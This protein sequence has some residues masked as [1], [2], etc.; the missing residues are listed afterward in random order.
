MKQTRIL[1]DENVQFSN[2]KIAEMKQLA[3]QATEAIAFYNRQ[4]MLSPIEL[5]LDAKDFLTDPVDFIDSSIWNNCGIPFTK[6]RP[7]SSAVAAMFG[8]NYSGVV[9]KAKALH[10]TPERLSLLSFDEGSGEVILPLESETVIR[11]QSKLWLTNPEEIAEYERLKGLCDTL[12]AAC[13]QYGVSNTERNQIERA[14]PF[15]S[16]VPSGQGWTLKP[17]LNAIR[18]HLKTAVA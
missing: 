14:V 1:I 17:N 4:P 6:S 13:D 7:E 5:T 10:M 16:C 15:I 2:Q 18:K 8:V 11:E 3:R 9:T 12:N